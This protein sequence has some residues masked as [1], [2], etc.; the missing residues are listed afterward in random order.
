MKESALPDA[1]TVRS[2]E[3]PSKY[4]AA[5]ADAI[6]EAVADGAS[7][8]A[9]CR[10]VGV[11]Y[12]TAQLWRKTKPDFADRYARACECRLDALEDKLLDLYALGHEVALDSEHGRERLQAVKLE[13]DSIKWTLCKLRPARY[14]ERQSVELNGN[15]DAP[16][17]RVTSDFNE[18][19]EEAQRELLDRMHNMVKRVHALEEMEKEET[20]AA[21]QVS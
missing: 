14:G 19:T 2:K 7:L 13:I 6:C 3:R 15:A 8:R 17:V 21:S 20:A 10:A 9:A 11:K 12:P 4:T 1:V 18:L 5:V 16:P